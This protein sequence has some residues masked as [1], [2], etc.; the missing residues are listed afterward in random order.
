VIRDPRELADIEREFTRKRIRGMS[1]HEALG[2]FTAL[3]REACSLNPDF[4]GDW[5]SDIVADVTM[6]RCLN[7]LPPDA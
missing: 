7:G 6:A 5:Q 3:W 4:P 2:I 1:Y